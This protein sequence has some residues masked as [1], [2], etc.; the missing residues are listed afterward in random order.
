MPRLALNVTAQTISK[1]CGG[2]RTDLGNQ[3]IVFSQFRIVLRSVLAVL[4]WFIGEFT[5]HHAGRWL[6]QRPLNP[7][8]WFT[9]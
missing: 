5:G 1:T 4:A 8:M 7:P 3:A 2:S 6:G 9:R